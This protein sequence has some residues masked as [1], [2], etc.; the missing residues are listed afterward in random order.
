MK[1]GLK[2]ALEIIENLHQQHQQKLT[3]AIE[4]EDAKEIAYWQAYFSAL[5]MV[6][7]VIEKEL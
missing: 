6:S 2:R 4:C 1:E 3:A 5:S 7:L